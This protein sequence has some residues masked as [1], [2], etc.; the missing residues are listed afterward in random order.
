MKRKKKQ[1]PLAVVYFIAAFGF[2]YLLMPYALEL[3]N[4]DTNKEIIDKLKN[5]QIFLEF[6]V[7]IVIFLAVAFLME[8]VFKK[9]KGK[10]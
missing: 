7:F 1:N 8:L 4:L 6:L 10:R 9:V 3:V 2:T 5:G